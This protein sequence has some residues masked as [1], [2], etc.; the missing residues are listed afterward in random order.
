MKIN[1]AT[2]KKLLI[3]RRILMKKLFLTLCIVF[4]AYGIV[5]AENYIIGK[6]LPTGSYCWIAVN[7]TVFNNLSDQGKLDD[8]IVYVTEYSLQE[9]AQLGI[10]GVNTMEE[11][12][13]TL[14]RHGVEGLDSETEVITGGD[15][16]VEIVE[17]K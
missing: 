1:Y 10:I 12:L 3:W 5:S 15:A 13:T 6:P 2:I 14:D 16:E 7:A 9:I 8:A 11:A 17:Y 4:L